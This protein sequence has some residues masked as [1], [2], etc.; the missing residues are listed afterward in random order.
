MIETEMNQ[1]LHL[2]KLLT[3][4]LALYSCLVTSL[5]ANWI[6]NDEN[7]PLPQSTQ[8]RTQLRKLCTILSSNGRLPKS[9]ADKRENLTKMCAKLK[10][11]DDNISG[12]LTTNRTKHSLMILGG[13]A[14]IYY[15]WQNFGPSLVAYV[16]QQW[17]E[18]N[19]NSIKVAKKTRGGYAEEL[20]SDLIAGANWQEENEIE[21]LRA[22]R[23]KRFEV[24][25]NKEL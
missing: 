18:L 3:V 13:L 25:A 9:Y 22:A 17:N 20:V 1:L 7:A 11:D 19:R 23:L 21:I 16:R 15:L 2:S 4:F 14:G 6:G 10:K 12:A 8:Y 5:E 24:D